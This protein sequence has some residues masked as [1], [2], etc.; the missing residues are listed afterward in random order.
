MSIPAINDIKEKLSSLRTDLD[1]LQQSQ[2]NLF[3]YCQKLQEAYDRLSRQTEI[4]VRLINGAGSQQQ[5][6]LATR[7]MQEMQMGFNS[8]FLMLQ[9][10]I[11]HENRQF[12]MI[13]NIMKNKHDTA[14][15][16]INN[17]R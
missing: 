14:K 13:S 6:L 4:L 8:Q 1:S 16:S 5:L 3:G 2:K 17:I 7:A 10:K 12:S 9:N 15:N 11:S